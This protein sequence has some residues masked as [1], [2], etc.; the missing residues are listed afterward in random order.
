MGEMKKIWE[1]SYRTPDNI[2][3]IILHLQAQSHEREEDRWADLIQYIYR[4]EVSHQVML[5]QYRHMKKIIAV[6]H[7]MDE[8][9]CGGCSDDKHSGPIPEVGDILD[10]ITESPGGTD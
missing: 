2:D 10:E 1:S 4:L 6:V 3:D 7:P 8:E 9:C 5:D